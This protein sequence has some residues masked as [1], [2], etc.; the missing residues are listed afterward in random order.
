VIVLGIESSCDD[1]AAAVLKDGALS[2]SVVS[3]Q[4]EVH[5]PSGTCSR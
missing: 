1:S 2:A 5:G 4:H 3:S